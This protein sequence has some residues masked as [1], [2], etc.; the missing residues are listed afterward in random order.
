MLVIF[1]VTRLIVRVISG[2]FR[3][4]EKGDLTIPWLHADTARATRYL[5]ILLLWIFAITVAYPYVP[6]SN[7]DAFKGVT[8]LVGVMISLG[9]AGLVNQIMSG[10]VV[11]YSR[12]LKPGELVADLTILG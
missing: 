5:V 12:A 3:Q 2:V 6:G 7:A 11:V 10:L 1:L 8:V 9:S 4:V